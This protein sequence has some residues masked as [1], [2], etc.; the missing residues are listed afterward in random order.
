MLKLKLAL[1]VVLIMAML[2]VSGCCCCVVPCRHSYSI[3]HYVEVGGDC[4]GVTRGNSD[5]L[6]DA[7]I[8]DQ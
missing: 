4:T 1:A 6:D 3:P 2:I 5:A 7:P 8:K